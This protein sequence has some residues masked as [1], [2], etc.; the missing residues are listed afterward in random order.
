MKQAFRALGLVIGLVIGLAFPLSA[1]AQ[2]WET[3]A[4]C[5]LPAASLKDTKA[6]SLEECQKLCAETSGCNASLF[7]SGW[8]K[9]SLKA[10]GKKQARLKF[11]SGELDAQHA[12]TP[13]SAKADNDYTGKDLERLVL[14]NAD[15]CGEA[16]SK[17]K[18]CVSFTYLEGYRV[19]WLKKT[20]GK[21]KPKV[22]S[23]SLKT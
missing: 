5:D 23:C 14:D 4:N 1:T 19:C 20:L 12:F 15:Q 17:N 3:K 9:C 13:G 21:F 2:T 8:G 18:E 11:H 22:F 10:D 6:K 7:I 16:C